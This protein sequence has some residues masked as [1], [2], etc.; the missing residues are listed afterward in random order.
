MSRRSQ[1]DSTNSEFIIKNRSIVV[2]FLIAI[3]GFISIGFLDYYL[4]T[5]TKANDTIVYYIERTGKNRNARSKNV[6]SYNYY[7][8]K[9]NTFA[10]KNFLV[11]EDKIELEY[12][13]LLKSV[14]NVKS[15]DA[16]YSKYLVNG[17]NTNG[18]LLYFCLAFLL[19][20]GISLK[21]L[22]SKKI[23]TENV[24]Y[25]IICFNGFMVFVCFYMFYL[26]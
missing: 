13:L 1:K 8:E 9:D 11:E 20:I 3:I 18:I 10:T 23:F 5:R 12:T 7:T 26:F 17:L 22:L 2:Y 16:D 4:L 24:F 25:N 6:I 19:S 21:I 15:K 14:T